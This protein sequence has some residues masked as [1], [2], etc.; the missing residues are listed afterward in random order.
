M[1][2]IVAIDGPSGSGKSSVARAVAKELD[3]KYLDTGAM[4]RAATWQCLDEGID[5]NDVD[6]VAKTVKKMPLSL[7]TNPDTEIVK[8]GDVDITEAIRESRI[9]E[10]VSAVATNKKARKFLVELQQD[11]VSHTK[12][13]IVAEGRDITTVIAPQARTR[14][15]LTASEAVRMQRRGLQLDN[16]LSQAELTKQIQERDKKDAKAADFMEA[17]PGVITIDSSDMDFDETVAA[18][19]KLVKKNDNE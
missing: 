19:L 18:V 2:D 9:S 7:G 16:E 4:Y 10:N 13:G 6:T 1:G 8:M 3:Y 15:L 11:V 12:E 17:A 14:I 5:L